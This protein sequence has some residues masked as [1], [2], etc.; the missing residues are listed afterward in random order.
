MKEKKFEKEI[1]NEYSETTREEI[2]KA[3]KT[4]DGFMK[5]YVRVISKSEDQNI[6]EVIMTKKM[7]GMASD[8]LEL[9][10]TIAENEDVQFVNIQ[11]K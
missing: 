3:I 8:V 7:F 2:L 1:D 6:D 5:E 4:V 10:T 11:E 9:V